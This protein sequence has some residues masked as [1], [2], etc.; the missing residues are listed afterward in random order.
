MTR[1][2]PLGLTMGDPAGIGPEIVLKLFANAPAL[3]AVVYGDTQTLQRTA[4]R[5]GLGLKIQTIESPTQPLDP[6]SVPVIQACEPLPS[7]LVIGQVQAV[8]GQAAYDCLQRAIDDALSHRIRAIVTAPLNKLAISQAGIDFPGHTE[9]LAH[10]CGDI[11]VAMMLVNDELRVLLVTIHM[12]LADVSRALSCELELQSIRLAHLA[13]QQFG[14]QAPRI[15]VAALNPH[16]GEGGK[17]GREDLDILVP[18]IDEARK[19]GIDASGP[20]PG[21]TVFTRARTGSFDIVVAQYHD[22]GLI[23]IKYLGLE[24]G[25]NVTVGLPFVRTSVDHGTAFDIAAKGIASCE[26]LHQAAKLAD[27]LSRSS[28]SP[29]H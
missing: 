19:E 6:L 14:I 17:F 23:P 4:K 7:D 1:L 20:W 15:A 9:I 21:D 29:I 3:T 28:A 24:H 12:A 2:A 13:C 11:P 16:A 10:R 22:Q 8:A 27:Q 5:L 26:S 25:V 18:A